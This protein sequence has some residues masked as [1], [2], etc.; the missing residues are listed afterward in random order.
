[1]RFVALRWPCGVCFAAIRLCAVDLIQFPAAPV[2][3]P[4]TESNARV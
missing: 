2:P 4:V 3:T 1:M